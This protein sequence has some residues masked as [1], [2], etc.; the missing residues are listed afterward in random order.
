MQSPITHDEF[1]ALLRQ[2]LRDGEG[3]VICVDE[4]KAILE[5]GGLRKPDVVRVDVALGLALTLNPEFDLRRNMVVHGDLR[6]LIRHLRDPTPHIVYVDD[7]F[8]IFGN[9]WS[10]ENQ[11]WLERNQNLLIVSIRSIWMLPEGV[12]T[13]VNF[14]MRIENRRGSVMV[15]RSPYEGET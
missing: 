9:P 11:V 6:A 5:Q 15:F 2:A 13:R 10:A 7:G 3:V 8:A 4:S 12:M 1:V 14:R